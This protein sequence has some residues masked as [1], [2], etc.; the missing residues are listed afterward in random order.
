VKSPGK[1]GGKIA[2]IGSGH[3]FSDKYLSSECN[4]RLSEVIFD[5]L[6]TD[7]IALNT[8]DAEDPEV[9]ILSNTFVFPLIVCAVFLLCVSV[10]RLCHGSGYDRVSGERSWLFARIFGR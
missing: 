9:T 4:D 6:T 2:V 7:D 5:F 8:L 3:V 10:T 1:K